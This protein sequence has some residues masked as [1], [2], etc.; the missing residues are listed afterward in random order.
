[1]RAGLHSF[2]L[3][4]EVRY[5]SFSPEVSMERGGV[6]PSKDTSGEKMDAMDFLNSKSEAH[7]PRTFLPRHVATAAVGQCHP[8]W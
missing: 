1:M 4:G 6:A 3:L 5:I 7:G 2:L 8:P